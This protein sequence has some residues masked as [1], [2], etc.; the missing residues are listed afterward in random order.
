MIM[1]RIPKTY[2]ENS[3]KPERKKRSYQIKSRMETI[4]A[5]QILKN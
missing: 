5:M 2:R 1:M 3:R 4:T